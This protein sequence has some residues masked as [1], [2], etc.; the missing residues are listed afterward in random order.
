MHYMMLRYFVVAETGELLNRAVETDDTGTLGLLRAELDGLVDVVR[1]A[2]GTGVDAWVN[3]EFLFRED[4][5]F[6][7]VGSFILRALHGPYGLMVKGPI[8][9]A[10]VD[11][12]GNTISLTDDQRA[13]LAQIHQILTRQLQRIADDQRR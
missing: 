7:K 2:E 8:V 4:L 5:E 10:G 6:N 12:E 13:S 11:D 9:F 1:L 3:D